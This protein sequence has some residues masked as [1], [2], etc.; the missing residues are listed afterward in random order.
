VETVERVVSELLERGHVAQPYLGVAVQAVPLPA[1][2]Q[3]AS[4]KQ[5]EHGLL[6][7]HVHPDSP[8]AKAGITLGDVLMDVD[9]ETLE[10][11][12]HLHRYLARKRTGDTLHLRLLRSGKA[13]EIDVT[14]GDRPGRG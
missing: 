6:V 7:M 9:G 4:G 13:L 1:E 5:Q 11:I 14:L 2:W 8:A 3:Q 10:D 12:R